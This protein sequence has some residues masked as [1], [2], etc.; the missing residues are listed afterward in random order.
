MKIQK[1]KKLNGDDINSS[2]NSLDDFSDGT[3]L[4]PEGK[5][6]GYKVKVKAYGDH[7]HD[8]Q[9]V[10]YKLTFISPEKKQTVIETEMCLM[11]GWNLWGS[12]VVK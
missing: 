10:D 9:M 4:I 2:L 3:H 5:L 6:T 8:G 1:A 11:V 7:R 12:Y